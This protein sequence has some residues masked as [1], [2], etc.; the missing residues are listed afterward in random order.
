[1][2]NTFIKSIYDPLKVETPRDN[3][4]I[5]WKHIRFFFYLFSLNWLHTCKIGNKQTVD[6]EMKRPQLQRLLS[7]E[8][9]NL[10][11]NISIEWAI[12]AISVDFRHSPMILQIKLLLLLNRAMV[13]WMQHQ[14]TIDVDS[15]AVSV[16]VS[17]SY[18]FFALFFF[19]FFPPI[20][21]RMS[22]ASDNK[23]SQHDAS[24]MISKS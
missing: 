1:M 20:T 7:L 12:K 22:T 5:E 16:V 3:L 18:H 15:C 24:R 9:D 10:T 11:T 4:K 14:S 6:Q 8:R 21:Q 2:F 13:F 19:S 17:F 23:A